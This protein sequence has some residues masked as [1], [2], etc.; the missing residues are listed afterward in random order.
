MS[1]FDNMNIK[2]YPISFIIG[3]LFLPF[4]LVAQFQDNFD[5]GDLTQNPAWQGDID[6][7]NVNSDLQLQLDDDVASGN[8]TSTLYVNTSFPDSTLWELYFKTDL[9]TAG[10]SA[11]NGIRVYLQSDT[12]DFSLGNGYYFEFGESGSDDAL[13]FYRMDSGTPFFLGAGQAAAVGGNPAI[14]RLKITRSVLGEWEIKADYTGGNNTITDLVFTDNTYPG[15]TGSHFG[16]DVN[17]S[18]S[19]DKNYFFDDFNV[20]PNLPDTTPP[21]VTSVD[22]ISGFELDV[23]FS[24][25]LDET[26]AEINSNYSINNGIGNPATAIL[27]GSN[28]SLVHLTFA[29]EFVS[30]EENILS[31][32]GVA[33]VVS[34]AMSNQDIPFTFFLV[35]IPQLYEIV[36]NEMMVDPNPVVGLPDAEYVELYN[37]SD[38]TFDLSGSTIDN[39]GTAQVFD[40]YIFEP[41]TYLILCDEDHVAAL[42]GYGNVLSFASFPGLSNSADDY[43][44]KNEDGAVVDAVSYNIGWYQDGNK[45]EGG[46]SLELVNPN[47][48]CE[49]QTNWR[50][51]E[52]ISGGT[53][54]RANSVMN[55][56]QS[57]LEGQITNVYLN[58]AEQLSLTFNV[59]VDESTATDP[60]NYNITPTI[61]I[62]TIFLL[63]GGGNRVQMLL[64]DPLE[65][66]VTYQITT[67]NLLD[68][69]GNSIEGT[70]LNFGKPETA[71]PGDLLI[72]E[73][74]FNPE[75]GGNDYLELYNQSDKTIDLSTL[76][77]GNF[78]DGDSSAIGITAAYLCVPQSYVA[79]TTSTSNVLENYTVLEP[80]ALRFSLLPGFDDDSGN[81]TLYISDST[82]TDI[83]DQFDYDKDFHSPFL[84]DENGVSLE[85]IDF[86]QPTQSEENWYSAAASTTSPGYGTP[87]YINSQFVD[88]GNTEDLLTLPKK[89]FS[90]DADNF[91]DLLFLQYNTGNPGYSADFKIY[92]SEGRLVKH[93]LRNELIPTEGILSWD[94]ITDDESKAGI[95]I[96]ILLAEFVGD[97][98]SVQRA[99]ETFVLAA[100]L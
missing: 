32:N 60:A 48:S 40:S 47:N 93:L 61:G 73:I 84:D 69:L 55:T 22:P 18:S 33:D 89:V 91:E 83:I 95:G 27:D 19:N 97:N 87:T 42:A 4:G 31:V 75:T 57:P 63:G 56:D 11:A 41:N 20:A 58:E 2:I 6:A 82:N 99:K 3:L 5:D 44:L 23:Y 50:A 100:K 72:N 76:A 17:Y 92:D 37:N 71:I 29:N 81:V 8:S 43:T 39:G 7:F 46:W 65:F 10:P 67:A 80:N 68:C 35:E 94:G 12:D 85:R 79:L 13:N 74:L 36:I 98:G 15:S 21:V 59:A 70:T 30:G 86:N 77:I 24:E 53:P 78:M 28:P 49:F 1:Q 34:N 62:N 64:S 51:S 38:K 66:G 52:D 96:Y 16:L 26:S 14:G 9:T 90:P 45:D 88:L 25:A 54:G